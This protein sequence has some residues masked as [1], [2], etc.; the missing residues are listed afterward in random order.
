MS[1]KVK[2]V[3]E[4]KSSPQLDHDDSVTT[5]N[6][7]VPSSSSIAAKVM[8]LF[9][10]S[11]YS[12]TSHHLNLQKL[13]TLTKKYLRKP[14][15]LTELTSIIQSC[16][17]KILSFGSNQKDN[18]ILVKNLMSFYISYLR[19]LLLLSS[20][21]DLEEIPSSSLFAQHMDYLLRRMDSLDKI[22]R[23][24]S[25]QTFAFFF[26][27]ETAHDDEIEIDC[28]LL[29][30]IEKKLLTRLT[31]KD[32]TVRKWAIYALK[33]FQKPEISNDPILL[34]YLRLIETDVSKDVRSAV[35][36][37]L[38]L[39][40]QSLPSF[41]SRL[42]DVQSDLRIQTIQKM[43]LEIDIR[44]LTS[45]QISH[46]V[47]H[48][49]CDRHAEVSEVAFQLILK[50][51]QKLDVNPPK[52][53][54]L[55]NLKSYHRE[56][57]Y[58]G[59][60]ILSELSSSSPQ[61]SQYLAMLKTN[62]DA[63]FTSHLISW[64]TVTF[65]ELSPSQL[66]WILCRCSYLSSSSSSSSSPSPAYDLHD[67]YL[68]D[69]VILCRLLEEGIIALQVGYSGLGGESSQAIIMNYERNMEYLLRI[70]SHVDSHHDH[71]GS[72]ELYQLCERV[73]LDTSS[74]TL[75]LFIPLVMK[76]FFQ[77]TEVLS[78][79]YEMKI[80]ELLCMVQDVWRERE[81]GEGVGMAAE[82]K[83]EG[84]ME[85]EDDEEHD[86]LIK[87]KS[88][89]ILVEI[90]QHEVSIA[91]TVS[92]SSTTTSLSRYDSILPILLNSLPM[93]YSDLR[94]YSLKCLGLL[95]VAS[96]EFSRKYLNLF[97]EIV[98]TSQED[99][100][101]RCRAME[102]LCDMIRIHTSKKLCS[103][104]DMTIINLMKRL[105]QSKNSQVA[106]TTMISSVKLLLT[107]GCLMQ[108]KEELFTQLVIQFFTKLQSNRSSRESHSGGG[109]EEEDDET[110]E[111]LGEEEDSDE[112]EQE[113]NGFDSSLD[114]KKGSTEY[115]NQFLTLFFDSY[116]AIGDPS[117]VEMIY[118]SI[119]LVVIEF[120]RLLKNDE[121]DPAVVSLAKVSYTSPYLPSSPPS[122]STRSWIISSSG[123][124]L[125]FRSCLLSSSINLSTLTKLS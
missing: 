117:R 76:L 118:A 3:Q 96:L 49:L 85:G 68:P 42:S 72:H 125:S 108:S 123:R 119:P 32:L 37:C 36:E 26:N 33:G 40:S 93:P 84:E 20:H 52:L 57:E 19:H 24:R 99:D 65:I 50:W 34:E 75:E 94:F 41:L 14:M 90:L 87:L 124:T 69:I 2:A 107:E 21:S 101:I 83:R 48:S 46:F 61:S 60:R 59:W 11:Q 112:D 67:L 9:T 89:Q 56:A 53:F 10:E 62:T 6:S 5:T 13:S 22:V 44:H 81:Q 98:N 114:M 86:I 103:S 28:D 111:G 38:C 12:H 109:G 18:L 23:F 80:Q 58:V 70:L 16:Y 55:M 105:I 74:H 82:G 43:I 106:N 51:I 1:R 30:Q 35:I 116:C 77:L 27:S 8:I 102:G 64:N 104:D 17:D 71:V 121:I 54:K 25:C 110:Q 39:C 78:L 88:L 63:I 120:C 7:I 31:D 66:L 100:A 29:E 4:K 15:E 79:D 92:S 113:E 91:S 97:L 47:T 45:Q 122:P 115:A 95:C 73:L